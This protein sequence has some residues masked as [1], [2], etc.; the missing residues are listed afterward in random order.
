MTD[1]GGGFKCLCCDQIIT[2]QGAPV[3]PE[4][5]ARAFTFLT[6]LGYTRDSLLSEH[7]ANI[8]FTAPGLAE[9]IEQQSEATNG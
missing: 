6:A 2:K 4:R 8:E 7:R 1:N 3:T 5:A 9:W